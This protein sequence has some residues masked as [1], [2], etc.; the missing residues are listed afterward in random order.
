MNAAN[1]TPSREPE[2]R[3]RI[4][5]T[6]ASIRN[7]QPSIMA[8]AET[9]VAVLFYVCLA[10]L[11]GFLF[12]LYFTVAL[13]PLVMMRSEESIAFG[14]RM[15]RSIEE[16]GW[17]WKTI[18]AAGIVGTI[19]VLS[20]L[21]NHGWSVAVL[22]SIAPIIVFFI[23]PIPLL[24]ISFGIRF[25]ATAAYWR[26]GIRNLPGNFTLL[27]FCT[28]PSQIPELVPGL[29]NTNSAFRLF[30]EPVPKLG[31]A[32]YLPPR[33]EIGTF[34]TCM[35]MVL[36]FP[37]SWLYRFT[38]K[39]T[40]WFWWPLAFLGRDLRLA[41]NPEL[42][43]WRLAGAFRAKTSV[44]IAFA[45]LALFLITNL[46]V[47]GSFF[48]SNPLITPIGYL[49]LFDWRLW[50]WQICAVA[51][52]ALSVWLAF[53]INDAGGKYRI[54]KSNNDAELLRS[55]A[56]EFGWIERVSRLRFVI[57]LAFWL[58]IGVQAILVFNNKNCFV[59]LPQPIEHWAQ[60]IYGPLYFKGSCAG[61]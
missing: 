16:T 52:S 40:A 9:I 56:T 7:R 11:T 19:G 30:P 22:L 1:I 46:F 26:I 34:I 24:L 18:A 38:V 8:F 21:G 12:P 6:E 39:S 59:T 32:T 28:S 31:V 27:I 61:A 51:S 41:R 5:S 17:L 60:Q 20:Y 4:W 25:A 57:V 55:T 15:F 53:W 23:V 36:L 2:I 49:L 14:V 10:S 58:L 29:V 3:W 47:D 45:S 33:D 13:A 48:K 42:L 35:W 37:P 43:E 44:T 50:P 54:A